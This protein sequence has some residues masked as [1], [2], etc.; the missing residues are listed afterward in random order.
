MKNKVGI[1]DIIFSFW[2]YYFY[3]SISLE[4]WYRI[5]KNIPIDDFDYDAFFLIMRDIDFVEEEL[6]NL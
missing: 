4:T 2:E 5:I 3:N 1:D 6:K